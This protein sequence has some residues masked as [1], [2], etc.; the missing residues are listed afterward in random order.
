MK[1]LTSLHNSKCRNQWAPLTLFLALILISPLAWSQG[2]SY[3]GPTGI[4]ITP[5]AYVSPSPSNG[6]GRASGSFHFLDGGP[7]LGDFSTASVTVGFAKRFEAGYTAEIH[8]NGT[9]P[10]LSELWRDDFSIVHGKANVIP[11]NMFGWK[12]VPAVSAGGVFRFNDKDLF[13]GGADMPTSPTNLAS[14]L[15]VEE[16]D[17]HYE[18]TWNGDGYVVA[19]KTITQVWSR[20]PITVSGGVR[21]TDAVLWGLGG[22]AP[23]F[24]AR[25]FGSAAAEFTLPYGIKVIPTAEFSQQPHQIK[26]GGHS[27]AVGGNPP[28]TGT[29]NFYSILDVPDSEAYAVRIIPSP[30]YRLNL[31]AGVLHAGNNI[32]SIPANLN[33]SGTAIPI[34]LDAK[35][36]AVFGASY[37][38]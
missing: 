2:L 23:L 35:A 1:N 16:K 24:K 32:G 25:G 15:E 27:T 3:E 12:W 36:R 30:K 19:T 33:T 8:A 7:V 5:T 34:R 28:G 22:D 9:N 20:M 31:D 10:V 18:R 14:L 37:N 38:F 26:Y 11:E 4:F 29:R 13:N 6:I 21:A 17:G